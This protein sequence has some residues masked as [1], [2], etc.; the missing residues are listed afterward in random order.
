M[1]AGLTLD[2]QVVTLLAEGDVRAMAVI[3]AAH[4]AGLAVFV[5]AV[6]LAEVTTGRSGP[7]AN[8]NRVTKRLTIV[9]TDDDT[10]RLAGQLRH[11]LQRP[12]ATVDA[13]IVATAALHG[14]GRVVS[15]D[16]DVH[17]LADAAGIRANGLPGRP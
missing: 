10:A 2:S 13:L 5:P 16:P 14:G 15:V 12:D 8:V 17:Q 6:V 9:A 3:K 11:E 7:D 4:D 1:A